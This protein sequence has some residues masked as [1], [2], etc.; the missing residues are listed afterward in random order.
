[1]QSE[2]SDMWA[3]FWDILDKREGTICIYHVKAHFKAIDFSDDSNNIFKYVG[4]HIADVLA[5]KGA[6]IAP[7]DEQYRS[8]IGNRDSLVKKIMR[9]IV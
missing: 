7:I 3:E 4:N 2:L 9:R 1:M 8:E 6:K 5:D